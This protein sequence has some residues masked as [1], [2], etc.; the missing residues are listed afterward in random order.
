MKT[1]IILFCAISLI[2]N[3]SIIMCFKTIPVSISETSYLLENKRYLFTLYCF[4]SV[5]LMLPPLLTSVPETL[6]VLP[7]LMCSGLMFSGASPLFKSGPDK[8]VHYVS[9]IISFV[10]FVIFLILELG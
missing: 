4:V 5:F 2:Y 3:I 7:F 10:S 9:A 6:T 1:L 8:K